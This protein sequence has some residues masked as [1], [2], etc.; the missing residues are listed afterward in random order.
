MPRWMYVLVVAGL[1]AVGAR[2]IGAPSLLI[3]ALACAG[4]I[5]MAGLIGQATEELAHHVGPK[6]G[7]LLNATFGNAAELIIL[8]AALRAG[9]FTLAKASITGSI[10]GNLLLVLG[11]SVLAG[12]LKNGVQTFDGRE[13]GRNSV[14]MLLATISLLLPATLQGV[15]ADSAVPRALLVEEVSIAVAAV[16]LLLYGAYIIYGLTAKEGSTAEHDVAMAAPHAP[17][18]GWSLPVAIGVLLVATAGTVL[19]AETLVATVEEATHLLGWSEFFVGVIIVPLVGN[20]AEHVSAIS[21]AY[22][23]RMEIAQAIAAGSSTQ[24]A[25]LVGPLA[26]FIS[27]LFHPLEQSL[28]LAFHPVEIVVVAAASLVF[29]YIS[30]DGESNWLEGLQLLGLYIIA[31]AVFFFLP[32]TGAPAA[33]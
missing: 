30:V 9:L 11:A 26:V 33:H 4:L 7:G 15:I 32:V 23:N 3:F 12:G 21:F 1:V 22:R 24:V 19:F 20:V 17:A 31:G 6:W 16:L 27:L 25:L 14:M 28:N 29:A 13:A 10:I 5:P 18:A 8:I 2:F